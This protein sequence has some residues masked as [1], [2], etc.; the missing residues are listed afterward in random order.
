MWDAAP[1]R[2]RL[3]DSQLGE[4]HLAHYRIGFDPFDVLDRTT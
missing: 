4:R 3:V 1:R 2:W